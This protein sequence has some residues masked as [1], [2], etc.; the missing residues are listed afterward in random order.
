MK[1]SAHAPLSR[2]K[3]D[4]LHDKCVPK[5]ES[6][7]RNTVRPASLLRGLLVLHVCYLHVV[8]TLMMVAEATETFSGIV[9]YD[10]V[11]FTDVHLLHCYILTYL[12]H[13]AESFLRS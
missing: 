8:C 3:T 10:K 11:Y 13:G 12:L 1:L 7:A 9:M 2:H 6:Y 4:C 5:T